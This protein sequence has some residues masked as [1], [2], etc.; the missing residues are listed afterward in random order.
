M[1]N[2]VAPFHL[3]RKKNP[4]VTTQPSTILPL[5]AFV[6]HSLTETSQKRPQLSAV[7]ETVR[8]SISKAS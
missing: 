8:L 6:L 1:R 2:E 4:M 3:Q 5:F 7:L